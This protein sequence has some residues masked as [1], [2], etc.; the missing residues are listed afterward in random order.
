MIKRLLLVWIMGLFLVTSGFHISN[1]SAHDDGNNMSN[2]IT[3]ND[4]LVNKIVQEKISPSM[5]LIKRAEIL[6]NYVASNIK[7]KRDKEVWGE[8]DYWQFPSTTIKKGTG[9]CEDQA[10]LLTSLLRAAGFSRDNVR[11][12]Y[13]KITKFPSGELVG[14]HCWVE[15]K[16]SEE[17][18][19]QVVQ[20]Y[21]INAEEVLGENVTLHT[22]DGDISFTIDEHEFE[23]YIA[24]GIGDRNGWIPLDTAFE[25][26]KNKIPTPFWMWVHLGYWV[27]RIGGCEA[28]PIETHI[29]PLPETK[30][31]LSMEKEEYQIGEPVVFTVT[32]TGE[33]NITFPN[34]APFIIYQII[35]CGWYGLIRP[36]YVP[37]AL[38]MLV[39]LEPGKSIN[40]S[41]DQKDNDRNQVPEG[42]YMV[43]VDYYEN[44][45]GRQLS[46]SFKIVSPEW[47]WCYHNF[48]INDYTIVKCKIY[49]PKEIDIDK[50]Y[51]IPFYFKRENII[52]LI[53]NPAGSDTLLNVSVFVGLG[54]T[55]NG[56]TYRISIE[57]NKYNK[58]Q[59]DIPIKESKSLII[60]N[61]FLGEMP[62]TN[63]NI[64]YTQTLSFQIP[65]YNH[66]TDIPSD[67]DGPYKIVFK[68]SK[69][70]PQIQYS[71]KPVTFDTVTFRPSI[72]VLEDFEF[73]KIKIVNTPS[74]VNYSSNNLSIKSSVSFGSEIS[75]YTIKEENGV[76]YLTNNNYKIKV[77]TPVTINN[78]KLFVKPPVSTFT[79][80]GSSY[81]P[82]NVA[83]ETIVAKEKLVSVKS[84]VLKSKDLT[85]IYEIKGVKEEKLLGIFSVKETVTIQVDAITGE[86]IH[87]KE[88]WWGFLTF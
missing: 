17:M 52:R 15:I 79:L 32:N 75:P 6:Y 26:V 1:T 76:Y 80:Y 73:D 77:E 20:L 11:L 45:E 63:T 65:S 7:Y 29:D 84:I 43:V 86:K 55:S 41:W 68:L 36:I 35:K 25:F 66:I 13:G 71:Y 14:Y 78:S 81:T 30:V 23:Q 69:T 4:E 70:T 64:K 2:Y 83:P 31:V 50:E 22:N 87:I 34:T 61:S 27:Y 49:L 39:T 57:L 19:S 82:V 18:L 56:N 37:I 40:F 58:W 59:I 8:K 5:S 38:Q 48:S 24:L 42:E 9:D 12:V 62:I 47:K 60:G 16:L 10:M 44:G 67:W 21:S 51:E 88:P 28:E 54:K 85:P 3:P 46:K 33:R 74:I 53:G 72:V